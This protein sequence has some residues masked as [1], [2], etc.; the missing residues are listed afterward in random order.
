MKVGR[1]AKRVIVQK[2]SSYGAEMYV[3]LSNV[4][5][6]TALLEKRYHKKYHLE[7]DK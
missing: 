6:D 2:C 3:I 7:S 5:I 1:C 4:A